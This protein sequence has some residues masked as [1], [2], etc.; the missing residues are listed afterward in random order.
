[1]PDAQ[2][3]TL[4]TPIPC[5]WSGRM[6]RDRQ[7]ERPEARRSRRRA[8]RRSRR[9][10]HRSGRRARPPRPGGHPPRR[11]RPVPRGSLPGARTA[12][13]SP[14]GRTAA[15]TN[16]RFRVHGGTTT[17]WGGQI[18]ELDSI[19]FRERIP[20]SPASGWP[21]PK[22][23]LA[24][25]YARALALEG[26]AGSILD[27]RTVWQGLGEPMPRFSPA[28][29][30]PRARAHLLP[31]PLV[32]PSPTSPACIARP[33]KAAPRLH[34]W[35][36]SNAVELLLEDQQATGVRCRTLSGV[37]A[38]FRAT[39]YAFCLGASRKSTRASSCSP[40]PPEGALPWNHSGLLGRHF[41]DHID[42][43]AA[44][45]PPTRFPRLPPPVF[46]SIFL[47]G[48]KYNP[49]LK[50]HRRSPAA[51]PRCSTPAAPSSPSATSIA[52]WPK[53]NSPPNSLLR[54][55]S[56]RI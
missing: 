11:R 51:P 20:G 34:L 39:D 49:K 29:L 26:V 2:T 13:T 50:P 47:G 28:R 25:H 6:I 38:V 37:E 45:A 5:A 3:E 10:R 46:D 9:R 8:H 42:S 16:G 21:I 22:R 24:P 40:V 30:L 15:S 56:A 36:H 12:A 18:L 33:S 19:D 7:V 48:F 4:A 41:Q 44:T 55:R 32:P 54:G 27:D 31:F 23:E 52:P 14:A 17:M 1:M 43:D 53:P 35:L